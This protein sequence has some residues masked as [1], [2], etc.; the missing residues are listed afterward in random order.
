MLRALALVG[1]LSATAE[2][3]STV[4][5][6]RGCPRRVP[7]EGAACSASLVNTWCHYPGPPD[8]TPYLHSV[9]C[10]RDEV[11]RRFVW[12]ERVPVRGGPLAPPELDA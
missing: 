7:A 12:A 3:Q 9:V 2:A 4:P 6:V 1:G 11:R 5:N 8:R 10:E